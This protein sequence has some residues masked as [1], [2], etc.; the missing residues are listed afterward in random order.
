VIA[1]A[2]TITT[3]AWT[4]SGWSGSPAMESGTEVLPPRYVV[5]LS[6]SER[7]LEVS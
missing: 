5:A 1:A 3:V 2:E 7:F 4:R 6:V